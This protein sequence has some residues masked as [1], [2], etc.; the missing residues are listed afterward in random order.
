MSDFVPPPP[1][2]HQLGHWIVR[3]FYTFLYCLVFIVFGWPNLRISSSALRDGTRY[4]EYVGLGGF[5]YLTYPN[6]QKH[7]PL[8]ILLPLIKNSPEFKQGDM[9][10]EIRQEQPK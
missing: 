8:F 3:L 10:Y 1:N 4:S 9:R 6:G 5:E 2:R 7:P